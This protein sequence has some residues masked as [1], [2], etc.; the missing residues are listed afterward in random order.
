VYRNYND[1]Q[2]RLNCLSFRIFVHAEIEHFLEK[3][4]LFLLDEAWGL[5]VKNKVPSRLIVSLVAY[6]GDI[7]CKQPPNSSSGLLVDKKK[8]LYYFDDFLQKAQNVYRTNVK[9]NHGIKEAN[10]LSLFLPV[11]CDVS[12]SKFF[13]LMA[14]LNSYGS[15][16]G[17]VAHNSFKISII[18]NPK[19][20]YDKA[21]RLL[22]LLGDLDDL[23]ETELVYLCKLKNA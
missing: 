14:D 22:G 8:N 23:V 6:S 13:I 2:I 3:R 12:V 17:S 7:G 20:E 1:E 16:R 11:G 5:W 9:N 15:E 4:V 19:D 21:I 10:L 18:P